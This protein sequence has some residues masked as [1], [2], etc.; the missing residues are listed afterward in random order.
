LFIKGM[1]GYDAIREKT[2][3]NE[4]K[5]CK[6]WKDR[7]NKE[8]TKKKQRRLL[9]IKY[10]KINFERI[11]KG[12]LRFLKIFGRHKFISSEQNKSWWYEV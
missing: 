6:R 10:F 2:K 11:H 9:N 4:A 8:E 3:Q 1:D 7:R 12:H 5:W